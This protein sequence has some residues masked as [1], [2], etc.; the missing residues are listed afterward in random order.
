[1]ASDLLGQVVPA[2]SDGDVRLVGK[3][4]LGHGPILPDGTDNRT[5]DT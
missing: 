4:L 3:G 2:V 1:M 5:P